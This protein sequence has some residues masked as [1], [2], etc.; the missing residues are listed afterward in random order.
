MKNPESSTNN[1]KRKI[2]HLTFIANDLAVRSRIVT[3]SLDKKK[4]LELDIEKCIDKNVDVVSIIK[5]KV[6]PFDIY[7]KLSVYVYNYIVI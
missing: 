3:I 5:D 2:S 6:L 4:D 1:K 7:W